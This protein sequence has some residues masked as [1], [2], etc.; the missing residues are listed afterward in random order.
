MKFNYIILSVF[1]VTNFG[2]DD[3]KTTPDKKNSPETGKP[4]TSDLAQLTYGS[5]K[6]LLASGK[7]REVITEFEKDS[8]KPNYN[9]MLHYYAGVAW[10]NLS[11]KEKA[12]GEFETAIKKGLS[13]PDLY[14]NYS[15]VLFF[16]KKFDECKNVLIS[17]MKKFPKEAGLWYNMG[18][19]LF[20][21][22]KTDEGIKY[23]N[24]ALLRNPNYAPALKSLGGYYLR[25]TPAKALPYF[26]K[27][28]G[29]KGFQGEASINMAYIYIRES[30]WEKAKIFVDKAEKYNASSEM[31]TR[32]RK[33]LKILPSISTIRSLIKEKKC[34]AA[35]VELDKLIKE[36]GKSALV[37]NETENYKKSC[38]K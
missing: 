2:C 30:N 13:F 23:Y 28:S 10:F 4:N 12:K 7:F 1:L 6:K 31:V 15:E 18:G 27:L 8:K 37:K 29:M 26:E 19:I 21:E 16:M 25:K 3:K 36:N 22:G 11:E 38:K 20:E 24:D 5:Y 9:P 34:K 35:K 33:V 14:V 17:A 32:F